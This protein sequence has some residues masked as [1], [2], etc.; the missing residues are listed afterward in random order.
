[1]PHIVVSNETDLILGRPIG[2]AS[3]LHTIHTHYFGFTVPEERIGVFTYIRY[4]PVGNI[5]HGGV[6]IFEGIN[7]YESDAAFMDYQVTMPYPDIQDRVITTA[8]GLRLEF[9]ELGRKMRI[10]YKSELEDTSFDIVQTAVTPLVSRASLWP[11]EIKD[12]KPEQLPGGSEQYMRS[13]GYL[14]LAGKKYHTSTYEIRDRSWNQVRVETEKSHAPI[15]WTPIM[16][17]ER[18]A[19]C[20]AGF[21]S[22]G[23]DS[24]LDDLYPLPPG[25]PTHFYGW[26]IRDG[27]LRDIVKVKRAVL[28]RH[29]VMFGPLRQKMDIEDSTGERYSFSAKAIAMTPC[30]AWPNTFNIDAVYRW[31]NEEGQVAYAKYMEAWPRKFHHACRRKFRSA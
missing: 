4:H 8:N 7:L 30:P 14:I 17:D 22:P 31:V 10:S 18:L 6:Q 27:E 21:E 13:E 28:E 25:R 16:F 2:Q 12:T 23:T 29:P 1:M 9:L 26:L 24:I 5:C 3:S 20:Q 15:G 19:L 11:D